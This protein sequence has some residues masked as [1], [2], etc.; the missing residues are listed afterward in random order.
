MTLAWILF[1]IYMAGTTWLGWMG[2][3]KTKNFGSFAIGTGDLH[4]FVVGITLASSVASAATFIINPGF[5]YVHGLAGFM[6]L[7]VSVGLG[8]CLMLVV[9]SFRFRQLGAASKALTMPHWIAN[10]YNSKNFGMFF[11]LVNL[12]ALA[13]VV[14]IVGGLSIVMQQLLGLSNVAALILILTFVT[15]YVFL[16][17]TYAHV[18]TNT[19]QGSLM[20]IVTVLI[21]GSGLHLFFSDAGFFSQLAAKDANL[22]K[23]I[24][25]ASNLFN[26]VFSI[27]VSGFLIGAA[28]VCQ[29]HILTKAL[30]VKSDKAVRQYLIYGIIAIALFFLLPFAGFYAAI[31]IPAEQI[32]DATTGTFRQDLVMTMYVKTAF[33]DWL[34]TFISVVLLAAGMS[35]LDGILVSLSTITANDLLLPLIGKFNKNNASED[36]LMANAYRL[37]HII[38]VVIAIVAF[39]ICLNPPKLLGIFGQVGVYGMAVAAVPPLVCGVLFRNPA[40]SVMWLA[41]IAGLALHFLLYFFGKQW[42]PGVNLAFANPGVT[43]SLAL[44]FCVLPGIIISGV[45]SRNQQPKPVAVD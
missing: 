12:F 44:I 22:V 4:P 16:G 3:R 26:D 8:F 29:P 15:G 32:V 41:S 35:T 27:Y 43:A 45:L 11:A 20:L 24:N 34:F 38:L 10:H 40:R 39:L 18:F 37:S 25:P 33:P 6:H 13:F 42:F 2:F 36:S 30:Y 28:L 9:L 21:I 7:G 31:T 14:L 1:L 17:G 5:V 23:F 19:L